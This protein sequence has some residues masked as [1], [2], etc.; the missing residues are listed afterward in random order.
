ML[1]L[2]KAKRI[3]SIYRLSYNYIFQTNYKSSSKV[4]L[5][6]VKYASFNKNK[7]EQIK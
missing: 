6:Y 4:L 7:R 2:L 1:K 5:K 3:L